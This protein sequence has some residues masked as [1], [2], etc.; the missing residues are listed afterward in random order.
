MLPQPDG[1]YVQ[2]KVIKRAKTEDGTPVGRRHQN[3]KMDTRQYEV[4]MADGAIEAYYANIIAENSFAQVDSE[5]SQFQLLDEIT[6]HQKDSSA[7]DPTDGWVTSRA[8]YK[9]RK[10]TTKGWKLLVK[11]KGGTSTDWVQLKDLKEAFPIEL[12]EEYAKANQLAEEPAF[13]CW[14]IGDAL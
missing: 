11:W 2:G 3:P 13:A 5:G 14:W 1:T 9:V 7:I 8:N 6:D 12:A 10:K 4:E